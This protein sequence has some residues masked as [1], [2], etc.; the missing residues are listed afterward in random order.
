MAHIPSRPKP[1]QRPN[2]KKHVKK[3]SNGLPLRWPK[4]SWASN[5]FFMG[6]EG[7]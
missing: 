4:S 3:D 1:N 7:C 2:N 6:Q 5:V